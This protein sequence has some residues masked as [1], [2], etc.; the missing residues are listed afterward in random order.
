ME[1]IF[2]ELLW[3][4]REFNLELLA[5]KFTEIK[6]KGYDGLKIPTIEEVR[7]TIQKFNNNRA[8]GPDCLN[9]E[10]FKIEEEKPIRGYRRW[11]RNFG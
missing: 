1:G 4:E 6:E 10:L 9:A 5:Y 2:L 3:R 7:D 8:P 11:W